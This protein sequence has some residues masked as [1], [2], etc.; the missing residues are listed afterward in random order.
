MTKPVALLAIAWLLSALP[1]AAQDVTPELRPETVRGRVMDDSGRAVVGATVMV[2]RGPDRLT[3]P[4]TTDSSGSYRVFFAEGTGD[5]LVYVSATGLGSAR[6]RVQRQGAETELVADFTLKPAVTELEAVR[7]AATRPV[8]ATNPVNPTQLETGA[9]E[10]WRDGVSGQLAPSVAGDLNAVAGTMSNVTQTATGPSILGAGAE[11]NLNTLNGMGM[12]SGS[13]PRAARTEVRVTGATFDPT[14]GGFAGANIDVRLEPGSRMYQRRNGF[15]TFDPPG[16][17]FADAAAAALGARSGGFRT[18]FG[19]DGELIR[20]ALTYNVALEVARNSSDPATLVSADIDA[21]IRA[22]VSPDSVARLVAVAGP[23]GLSLTGAGIPG[24]RR[25]DAV[26]WLGRLDDTRDTLRTRALTTMIGSTRDGALGFGPLSAPSAAGERRERTFGGQLTLGEYVGPGRRILTETRLAASRVTTETS[27]Y[28]LLPGANVLV[29][30]PDE[31]GNNDVAGLAVGGGPFFSADDSRWTVEGANET[32]WNV[33]GRKHRFK[34]LLWGRADGLEQAGAPNQL[35]T[36]TF[37]SIGDFAAGTP[38]SFSRTLSQPVRNGRVWNAAGALAHHYTKSPFFN[39]LYGARIEGSGFL[40]SPEKN[41]ALEQALGVQTGAAPRRMRVSPRFGFSYRY[42]RDRSNGSGTNQS[43]IGRFYRYSTGVIRGGVGEFRDL[44][45]PDILADASSATGLPGGSSTLSCVGSATPA[46]DWSLFAADPAA[47][48]TQCLDGSG[49]LGERAPG[50]TLIHPS[51]DVPR[52]WRATLDWSTNIGSWLL[53]AGGLASYDLSQP[54]VVDANF[55]GTPRF[56]LAGESARPVYVSPAAIDPASGAVSPAESRAS[57]QFG[58]VSTRVSDL[59]GYG[60]QLTFGLSPDVFRFRSRFQFYSSLNYTLQ[61]TRRQYRGFDGAAVGDPREREWAP[62]TSDARHVL[63]LTGAFAHRRIGTVTLFGR[64]QSGLPFTPI[65]QGD[66]NGDGRG[67]DRAFVPDPQ[68]ESDPVLAAQISSLMQTGPASARECLRANLGVM[69][70]RNS[71]RGPGTQSLN[72]QWQPPLPRRW[73]R[74]VQPNVYF[75]NVLARSQFA[76]PVLLLPRAFDATGNRFL[77]DVNPRFGSNRAGRAISRDP[78]RVVIDFSVNL[79]TDFDLQELRRAVE[80]VRS[81]VGWE[82]RGADSITAFYLRNTSSVHK[83]LLSESD[84]LFLSAE[85]IT[86]LRHADSV[87]SA[88]V[89]AVYAPL[90]ELLARGQ[91]TAG[92]AELDSAL[93]TQRAYWKIFWEQPEIAAEI[94]TPAQRELI[95]MFG[96]MLGTPTQDRENSRW[97]FGHPVRF[98]DAPAPLTRPGQ[99]GQEQRIR[100]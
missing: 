74:R 88:R 12:A 11:S 69:P 79:S 99:G 83:L 50:V 25:R 4:G 77:Y 23:L 58:R 81:P 87:Y 100:R 38:S 62:N 47:I 31:G 28:R 80:P 75:Q 43:P 52:S 32:V 48:P 91:G 84:S 94:V 95:P 13:I 34:A 17:Q 98:D 53:R 61:W 70:G 21:L 49:P 20:R 59:R 3:Q 46:A 78:F 45:R 57:D 67:G 33:S 26:S 96:R 40:E 1:S 82:R 93:A 71:C 7:V 8:R 5:Y 9:A 76:D 60:G 65:V 42:N 89:R 44:L 56:T 73:G 64:A 27:P 15:V 90:G 63:V 24:E 41:P 97:Q 37:N 66:V 2:T 10:R 6:R 22:G 18:S 51:Y 29:R 19:A 86:R 16:L 68:T 92:K 35:G 36:F 54:G 85:Q 55:S 30:S 72:V 14:R 39:V